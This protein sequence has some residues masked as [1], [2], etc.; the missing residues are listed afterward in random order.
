MGPWTRAGVLLTLGLG[1]G[2]PSLKKNIETSKAM[3]DR[4]LVT[5][6]YDSY[7]KMTFITYEALADIESPDSDQERVRRDLPINF[8]LTLFAV[9]EYPSEVRASLYSFGQ[10]SWLYLKCHGLDLLADNNS[11]HP[12][13]S[14]DGNVG[15]GGTEVSI[16]ETVSFTLSA[17]EALQLIG[18]GGIRG[19][20]CNDEFYLNP[21][22]MEGLREFASKAGISAASSTSAPLP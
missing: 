19:R 15:L 4:G 22:Q 7:K 1:L 21:G 14:H 17:A 16:S 5:S 13:T 20:L 18:S 9:K 3:Q 11:L 10:T 12:E 6:E 2:C 8:K